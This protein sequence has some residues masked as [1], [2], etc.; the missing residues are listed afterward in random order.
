MQ[1]NIDRISKLGTGKVDVVDIIG[2]ANLTDNLKFGIHLLATHGMEF[3]GDPLD[4]VG[5]DEYP[6]R[7]VS[8]AKLLKRYPELASF[9]PEH[10]EEMVVFRLSA[11]ALKQNTMPA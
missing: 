10:F 6:L 7:L 11:P 5:K 2:S 8:A 1:N 9:A 4:E 3:D